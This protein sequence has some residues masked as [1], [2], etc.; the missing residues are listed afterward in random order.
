MRRK[1]ALI[2]LD[3]I[4]KEFNILL[5]DTSVLV[6]SLEA[7]SSNSP[8]LIDKI[9][10]KKVETCSSIFFNKYVKDKGIFF[11]TEKIYKEF[12][13][14][15]NITL[16]EVF[17]KIN[18]SK[19]SKKELKYFSEICSGV[20]EKRNLLKSFKKYKKIITLDDFEK[21]KYNEIF[22]RNLYL[23]KKA[24]GPE[25]KKTGDNDDDLL[26]HGAVLSI[27]RDKTA[28]LSNDFPL[29]YAYRDLLNKEKISPVNYG[30]FIRIKPN[31]FSRGSV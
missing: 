31:F 23:K 9:I 11:L 18:R 10:S 28:I 4:C 2:H 30:F 24:Y 25:G 7:Q 16:E 29:L 5:V 15:E 1:G 20:Q 17:P 22:T 26:I 14:P 13:C 19:I 8:K 27:T 6:K 3:D 21:E 12:Y